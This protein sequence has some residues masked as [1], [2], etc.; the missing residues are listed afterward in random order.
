M[1]IQNYNGKSIFQSLKLEILDLER[2]YMEIIH[3]LMDM[4]QNV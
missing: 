4:V 1:P 2:K 3:T